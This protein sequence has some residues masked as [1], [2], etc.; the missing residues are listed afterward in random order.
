MAL[1][2]AIAVLHEEYRADS[3]QMFKEKIRPGVEDGYKLF[4][5]ERQRDGEDVA[6]TSWKE[7]L[8][9]IGGG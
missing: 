3:E 2:N 8:G 5:E 1:S 7:F 6:C 4:D 9:V